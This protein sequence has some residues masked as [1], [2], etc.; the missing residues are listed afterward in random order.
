MST[1]YIKRLHRHDV[2]NTCWVSRYTFILLSFL[3][4]FKFLLNWLEVPSLE[5]GF[6][7]ILPQ[8]LIAF[9]Y[10][11]FSSCW[12]PF[13][14]FSCSYHC[15]HALYRNTWQKENHGN[16]VLVNCCVLFSSFHLFRK[17]SVRQTFFVLQIIIISVLVKLTYKPTTP[18]SND[19]RLS[20]MKW[21]SKN[22]YCK[23][24]FKLSF[25]KKQQ[26]RRKSFSQITFWFKVILT[27]TMVKLWCFFFK[28][29]PRYSL[30]ASFRKNNLGSSINKS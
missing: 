19:N 2:D 13:F 4:T 25:K 8:L 6:R 3:A 21:R 17:V 11:F 24:S 10:K 29:S 22:C 26:F 1:S 5:I 30:Q 14:L 23:V 18:M 15:H 20:W 28:L 16:T 7:A 12:N 9:E 27:I